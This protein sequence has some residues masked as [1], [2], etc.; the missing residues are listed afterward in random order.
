MDPGL[1]PV[2]PNICV[3][4]GCDMQLW[5]DC[6]KNFWCEL[7]GDKYCDNCWQLDAGGLL[8]LEGLWFCEL[9][10]TTHLSRYNNGVRPD[11]PSRHSVWILYDIFDDYAQFLLDGTE[12]DICHEDFFGRYPLLPTKKIT[13]SVDPTHLK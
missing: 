4:C 3:L 12:L 1:C 11:K 8:A 5:I 9:C 6:M 10:S 7:C 13:T 2:N